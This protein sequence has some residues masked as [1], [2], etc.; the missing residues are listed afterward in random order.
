MSDSATASTGMS[1]VGNLV[2]QTLFGAQ[3]ISSLL[4]WLNALQPTV[5]LLQGDD[6]PEY[7]QLLRGS[8]VVV[9]GAYRSSLPRAFSPATVNIQEVR[10]FLVA[11]TSIPLRCAWGRYICFSFN[12]LLF[13]TIALRWVQ[14][15]VRVLGKLLKR[16][17]ICERNGTPGNLFATGYQA[18][19]RNSNGMRALPQLETYTFPTVTRALGRPPWRKLLQRVGEDALTFL[20][21]NCLLFTPLPNR[22]YLQLTGAPVRP[23]L[24]ERGARVVAPF[25]RRPWRLRAQPARVTA[26]TS[27]KRPAPPDNAAE[28]R[29][30][31]ARVADAAAQTR[32]KRRR[33]S[34]RQRRQAAKRAR[35]TPPLRSVTSKL[36]D[37][38]PDNGGGRVDASTCAFGLVCEQLRAVLA[39]PIQ[40]TPILYN[41][42][43]R[44]HSGRA[45]FPREREGFLVLALAVVFFSG[46]LCCR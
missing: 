19:S 20:F 3:H 6:K 5:P 11:F 23:Q 15:I 40:R 33:P 26:P 12:E 31:R 4:D 36:D 37:D 24:L 7:Q 29:R 42:A 16:N 44:Q 17:E 46:L 28:P 10:L 43:S 34:Q 18:T 8:V 22:C 38:Q 9:Q 39:L 41:G 32:T 13:L 27:Q 1:P 21:A 45:R 14:V 25:V 30:K 35:T 2:L